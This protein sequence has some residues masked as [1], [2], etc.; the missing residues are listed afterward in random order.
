[1]NARRPSRLY[2]QLAAAG[3]P[4]P[5]LRVAHGEPGAITDDS[6]RSAVMHHG[7]SGPD[8]GLNPSTA[9]VAL[10][11]LLPIRTGKTIGIIL[12]EPAARW[13]ANRTQVHYLDVIDR[14]WGR[15]GQQSVEDTDKHQWTTL[16]AASF[17]AQLATTR[18]THSFV[19]GRDLAAVIAGIMRPPHLSE[20]VDVQADWW[21]DKIVGA[22]ENATFQDLFGKYV[23][24]I[25]IA[26]LQDRRGFVRIYN[27]AQRKQAALDAL[28]TVYPITRSQVLSP[29]TW[30][31]GNER[32]ENN[33]V[34][35]YI[36]AAGQ[37]AEHHAVTG[38]ST[39]APDNDLDW[40]HIQF[41]TDQYRHATTL[42]FREATLMYWLPSI[43]F[44]IGALL[45]SPSAYHRAQAGFL[46][47]LSPGS[48]VTFSGDWPADLQGVHFATG[49]DESIEPSGWTLTLNLTPYLHIVGEHTPSVAPLVWS[50]ATHPWSAEARNWNMETAS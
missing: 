24:D 17:T 36:N 22:I 6:I 16:T 25:G 8:E 15:I 20:L 28:E 5:L 45:T 31:Q 32:V 29:T 23:T 49:I 44:D 12:A 37:Q 40:T 21:N 30:T 47:S 4:T 1:M 46:L 41:F 7:T 27:R 35:H 2:R 9:E 38:A 26:A 48:P 10:T 43:S 11:T 39:S 42:E 33:Y 14:Y 34:A 50:S 3:C 19:S 13:I 18:N